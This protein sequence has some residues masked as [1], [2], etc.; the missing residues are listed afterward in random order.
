MLENNQAVL[1]N[2]GLDRLSDFL[3]G[4]LEQL[5]NLASQIPDRAFIFMG[6]YNDPELTQAE[7]TKASDLLIRMALEIEEEAPLMIIF[8]YAAAEYEVINFADE[9][10]KQQV[11]E[12]I[13]AFRERSSQAVQV[14]IN[15]LQVTHNASSIAV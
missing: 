9:Q 15:Q 3:M 4:E 11:A 2:R 7:I 12:W 8:E 13:D 14:E 1:V 6:S 10:R 5:T